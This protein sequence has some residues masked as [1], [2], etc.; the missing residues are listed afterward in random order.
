MTLSRRDLLKAGGALAGGVGLSGLLT[1]CGG[2]LAPVDTAAAGFGTDASG[3]VDI[4]CRAATQTGTQFMA[5]TFNRSQSQITVRVIPVPDTQFVTKLATAIRGGRVP[6]LVDFDDI[7]STLFAYHGAFADLTDL[8][9]E[10]PGYD[11]LSPRHLALA[12]RDGR[13]YAVP[14]LADNSVLFC[15][16]DLFERAGLDLDQHTQDFDGLLE[17]ATRISALG[18]DIYGWTYPANNPGAWGFTAQP[19]IWAA[20]TD[21][22]KGEIGNQTGNVEGNAAVRQTLNFLQTLWTKKLVPPG[23]Y[24]DDAST[25]NADYLAG[26]IGIFPASYGVVVPTASKEML[27]KSKIVLIPGPTGGRSF[28]DGGDNLCLLNGAGNPSAAW[29]FAKYCVSVQQQ[30]R[31]PEGGYT[32]IRSDAATDDFRSKY[33]FAVPTIVDID[34]G[35][36]PVTLAYNLLYNQTDGPWLKM[37]RRAAF[38]QQTEA[39]M[40]EAQTTFDRLL[41][42]TQA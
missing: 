19:H 18:D 28:F 6:D 2:A 20:G 3:S 42:Q 11:N 24:S 8:I 30:V 40:A 9:R 41:K 22:I 38:Q 29:Q 12:T 16:T 35:Y 33:P 5:D 15:N 14:F 10:L 27:A 31:F 4:W 32:P 7:N 17:A 26:T 39:A 36:A 25:W 23:S 21:L 37:L 13:N 34:K 1:G